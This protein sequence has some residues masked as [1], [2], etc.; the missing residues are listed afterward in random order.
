M[1]AVDELVS[2]GI[3]KREAFER[4]VGIVSQEVFARLAMGDCPPAP[5]P[6]AS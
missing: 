2:A 3:V 4:A 6:G 1:L 5:P